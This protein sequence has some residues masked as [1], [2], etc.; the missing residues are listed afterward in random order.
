VFPV[1]SAFHHAPGKP[2]I[3]SH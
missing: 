2:R 3:P 1:V